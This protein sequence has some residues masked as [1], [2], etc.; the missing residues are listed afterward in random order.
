MKNKCQT[1]IADSMQRIFHKWIRISISRILNKYWLIMVIKEIVRSDRKRKKKKKCKLSRWR[2]NVWLVVE[3]I[4]PFTSQMDS[5][6]VKPRKPIK[7]AI[8]FRKKNTQQIINNWPIA[9]GI[10]N[11]CNSNSWTNWNLIRP[12]LRRYDNR[13]FFLSSWQPRKSHWPLK[14]E[15]TECKCTQNVIIILMI[16]GH[17]IQC[18]CSKLAI[19]GF[20]VRLT[21]WLLN[22]VRVHI[23]TELFNASE[24]VNKWPYVWMFQTGT[25]FLGNQ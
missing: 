4:E 24:K 15:R 12:P 5:K 23:E 1:L 2:E 10:A 18:F 19:T 3:K 22:V 25:I 7:F 6:G 21:Q 8:K 20:T 9:I 13:F 14:S 16:P 11:G 17:C